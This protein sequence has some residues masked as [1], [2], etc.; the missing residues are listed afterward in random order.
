MLSLSEVLRYFLTT[1]RS[2]VRLEE[3]LA[4]IEAYLEI[5]KARLGPRLSTRITIPEELRSVPIPVLSLE[6]LVENAIKHGIASQPGPGILTLSGM[7][8]G[9][10]L[11]LTVHD[12]GPGPVTGE[13]KD[14][15]RVGL[16]NVRRRLA[17]HYGACATLDLTATA[18]GACATLTLPWPDSQ[19]TMVAADERA[20]R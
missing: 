3:E 1:S 14:S 5:E 19:A 2:T 11:V 18:G 9:A 6:P 10:S 15:N 13:A 4:I 8:Q 16:E 12:T 20:H 7:R 17:L